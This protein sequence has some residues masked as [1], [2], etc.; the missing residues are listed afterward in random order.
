MTPANHTAPEKQLLK[1]I[2]IW[3]VV[4][5]LVVSLVGL[6]ILRELNHLGTGRTQAYAEIKREIL[7]LKK[8]R[9]TEREDWLEWRK[10][11]NRQIEDLSQSLKGDP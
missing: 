11:V 3:I 5:G 10:E 9:L 8:D 2:T 6:L 7:D 4:S 1:V